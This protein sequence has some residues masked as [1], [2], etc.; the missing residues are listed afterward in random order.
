MNLYRQEASDPKLNAQ[1]NLCGRT[2]Y[3][4]DDT[5]RWHKSRVLSARHTDGGLLFAIITSDALD[6]NNTRR[7]FRYVIFDLF[8]NTVARPDLEHAYRTSEQASNAMW[9]TLSTLD[10][11]RITHAAIEQAE[12]QH[13]DDMERVRQAVDKI[14]NHKAA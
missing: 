13:M 10:A 11:V 9:A 14:S 1:R 7:G 4:D 8:G 12:K 6:M 5:L 3:V 2:H